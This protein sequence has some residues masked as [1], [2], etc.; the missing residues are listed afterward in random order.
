MIFTDKDSVIY[1]MSGQIDTFDKIAG[2]DLDNTIIKT[3]SGKVFPIDKNDWTLLND[4]VKPKLYE[5]Y[6]DCHKIVI[7]T[8]QLGIGK[9]KIL[10][11]DFMEK[12]ENIQKELNIEFDIFI[13]TDDDHY[14][15]PMIGMW[16][17]FLNLHQNNINIKKSFYCGDAAGREDNWIQ[18]RKKDFD[19]VDINFAYNIGLKFEIPENIFSDMKLTLD[20]PKYKI[21]IDKL[22]KTKQK[23]KLEPSSEREMIILSGR[24]GSGKSELCKNIAQDPK[25]KNYVY[26]NRDTCNTD[27]KC[28]KLAK[29]GIKDGKSLLI[30][31]TNS[32]KKS[33][34]KYI[35]LAK[36]ND[37]YVSI[38]KMDISENLSKHLEQMRVMKS[39]GKIKKIPIVAYRMYNK[40]YEAPNISEGINKIINIPFVFKGNSNDIKLFR[41][42][43]NI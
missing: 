17:L 15:K 5:Y 41:Y 20:P 27:A 43:Y 13:A 21:D 3:K 40:K 26:I 36:A 18:G 37:M 24:Q 4:R 30:D 39:E 33:R 9:G 1:S 28:I 19:S 8:N 34:K 35:D 38:Y 29:D 22:L 16:N 32:D 31:N 25:F 14:R 11:N 42:H 10:K 6:N 2:F 7:F 23:I 12:I